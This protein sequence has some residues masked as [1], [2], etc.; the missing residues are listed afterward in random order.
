MTWELFGAINLRAVPAPPSS[1]HS[2]PPDRVLVVRMSHL[3]DIVQTLPL[4]HALRAAWPAAEFAWAI[5]PEFAALVEPLVERTIHFD[6]RGGLRAWPRLRRALRDFAA[7]LA[8]DAQGNWKSALAARLSGAPRRVTLPRCA[9]QEQLAA[10]LLG[11]DE[12]PV[13]LDTARHLVP[14]C[15]ALGARLTGAAAAR[16]DPGLS[17]EER[18]D[19]S[20]AWSR[21]SSGSGAVILH[22]G[23]PGDPR[24]WPAARYRRLAELL[25]ERG[26][27][28]VVLTGPAEADVGARLEAEVPGA[29]HHV[30]QRG[31]REFAA[32]LDAARS[33]GAV[34]VGGDSGPAHVA[35]SVG[36]PVHLIAGPEDP[37]RTGPW[38]PRGGSNVV[39]EDVAPG[40]PWEERSVEDVAVDDVLRSLTRRSPS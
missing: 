23:A 19:A 22:P 40:R 31:L 12:I 11:L 27:R 14:L 32:L 2:P 1:P 17:E 3:G 26:D 18:A 13:D 20:R 6:R 33:R 30:G 39:V 9:R 21:L 24:S 36:L 7:D 5:Q 16:V 15:D 4:L 28:V 35:A 29:A 34:L 25:I 38:P 37:S 8:V 10:R